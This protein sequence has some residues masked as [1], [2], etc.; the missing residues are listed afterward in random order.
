MVIA[1]GIEGALVT[2]L[3]E[4]PIAVVGFDEGG[5]SGGKFGAVAIGPTVDDLFLE[6]AVEAFADAVGCA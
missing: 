2:E 4:A 3:F 5:D 1:A 6:G